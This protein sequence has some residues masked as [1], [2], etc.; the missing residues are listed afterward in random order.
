MISIVLWTYSRQNQS[1]WCKKDNSLITTNQFHR[2]NNCNSNLNFLIKYSLRVLSFISD[3]I[4]IQH[5]LYPIQSWMIW[6]QCF[7]HLSVRNV[8][9][10][11]LSREALSACAV[12]SFTE[13]PV[14]EFSS[15]YEQYRI[16]RRFCDPSQLELFRYFMETPIWDSLVYH[17]GV[18]LR[19]GLLHI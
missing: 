13:G 2:Y 9:G 3:P 18:L 6:R 14:V 5:F 10:N 1:L 8:C 11:K 16:N 12:T 19:V 7:T 4:F 15:M 17:I